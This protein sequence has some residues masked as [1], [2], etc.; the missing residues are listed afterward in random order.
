MLTRVLAIEWGSDGIR[1]NSVIPGPIEGTEGIKRL[2]PTPE[3]VQTI[4]HS[5]P[6]A[7]MGT[8]QDV[9]NLVLFLASP[10]ATY[11]SGAVIPVDGGWSLNGAG[12]LA[13]TLRS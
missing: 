13:P 9:A 4:V 11:I 10:W 3:A 6:L 12:G 8:K 1:V 7:R 5:V 2:A